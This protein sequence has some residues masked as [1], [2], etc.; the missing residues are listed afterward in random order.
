VDGAPD[1]TPTQEAGDSSLDT[2]FTIPTVSPFG[3]KTMLK[4][5]CGC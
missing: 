1:L 3:G 2:H 4:L 5:A